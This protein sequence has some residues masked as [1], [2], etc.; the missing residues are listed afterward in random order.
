MVEG[1]RGSEVGWQREII[2]RQQLV[3]RDEYVC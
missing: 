1:W 2:G 3:G